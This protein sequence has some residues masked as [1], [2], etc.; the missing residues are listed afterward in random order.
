MLCLFVSLNTNI[1]H[2]RASSQ[3]SKT[4]KVLTVPHQQV[5]YGGRASK[6]KNNELTV[7]SRAISFRPS[8][9]KTPPSPPYCVGSKIKVLPE[10]KSNEGLPAGIVDDSSYSP[11]V[12]DDGLKMGDISGGNCYLNNHII[13]QQYCDS[14]N[15]DVSSG[16]GFK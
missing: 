9:N 6:N 15:G 12:V 3:H 2:L 16:Y 8:S 7:I 11:L 4:S 1:N 13:S 14:N 5:V 10:G